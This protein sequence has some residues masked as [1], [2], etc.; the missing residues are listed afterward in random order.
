MPESL[1]VL[2]DGDNVSGR[3]GSKI[4]KIAEQHG[5]P[6]VLRVYTNAQRPSEWHEAWGYEMIHAGT[7]KNATDLLLAI[8]AMELA[9]S[10][11][12]D[13]FILASSDGDFSHLAHRLRKLGAAVT[14]V[15]EKKAPRSFRH[16]C[17]SFVEIDAPQAA[18]LVTMLNPA[19]TDL[20]LKIRTMIAANSKKG[21][22]MRIAALGPK[23]H[24]QYGIR[25]SAYAERNWRAYL[26]ARPTL[27]DLDP[28]GPDAMVRFRSE[29]FSASA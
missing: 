26:A 29:A 21:A 27:Y 8:D 4:I 15:G 12:I 3:H 14:G 11:G 24:S 6:I 1:A 7:G 22:G 20:D 13:G 17:S 19:I 5:N 25:I 9:F 18:S 16:A 10:H 28:R 23:M 2:V